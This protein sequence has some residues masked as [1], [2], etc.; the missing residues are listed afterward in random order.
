MGTKKTKLWEGD[1]MPIGGYY[2]PIASYTSEEYDG[3]MS[4]EFL[5]DKYFQMIRDCGV[6]LITTVDCD[7]E[8]SPENL[9][10]TMELCDRH[11]INI[12]VKDN[13]LKS[14]MSLEGMEERMR[15]YSEYQSFAGIRVVDEPE[16]EY[17]PMMDDGASVTLG[18]PLSKF[19]ELASK[20]SSFE[21][22]IG[23][24]NLFPYYF[25]METT[26]ED[27]KRYVE[28]YC[29]TC[30]PLKIISFDHYLFDYEERDRACKTYFANMSVIREAAEKYNVPYWAFVQCGGQWH[31]A[32][33]PSVPYF[34]LEGEFIWNV[35]TCLA[36]GAKGIQYFPLVQPHWFALTPDGIDPK[37]SGLI[38]A[39]GSATPWYEYAKKANQQIAAVDEILMSAKH[40]GVIAIGKAV[41]HTEDVECRIAGKSFH[42]LMD[43]KTQEAGALIGCFDYQGKTALYVVNYD[44]HSE[45]EITLELNELYTITKISGG[46]TAKLSTKQLTFT[47]QKG[48]AVLIVI[49]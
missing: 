41:E 15:A 13:G 20:T 18:R 40:K 17:F 1:V 30:Q 33:K 21:N 36:M 12:F 6:N 22:L 3:Y 32:K 26:I 19:Q 29:S 44:M 34:P 35:N 47:P 37:R 45:Q 11:Q 42:E 8:E 49:E 43:V 46:E 14:E 24:V 48:E 23:Y 7:Y 16:V 31:S 25:W 9:I 27:Y 5:E 2:G 38:A 4:K 28:E 39:D 10:K